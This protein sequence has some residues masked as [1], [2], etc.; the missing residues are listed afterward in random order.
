VPL[1]AYETLIDPQTDDVA[2]TRWG[3]ILTRFRC[4]CG[5]SYTSADPEAVRREGEHHQA[6]HRAELAR[7]SRRDRRMRGTR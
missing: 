2:R 5:V 7:R 6:Q 3:E 1:V 4:A